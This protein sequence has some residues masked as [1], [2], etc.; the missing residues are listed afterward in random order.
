MWRAATLLQDEF[1]WTFGWT[2]PNLVLVCR[3]WF[4]FVR[5]VPM[6]LQLA[7]YAAQYLSGGWILRGGCF[8]ILSCYFPSTVGVRIGFVASYCKKRMKWWVQKFDL[9]QNSHCPQRLQFMRIDFSRKAI[10]SNTFCFTE[11]EWSNIS[12]TKANVLR[13][14]YRA[15]LTFCR[16]P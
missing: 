10:N 5:W 12:E 2:D 3:G 7:W 4:M 14:L 9:V 6:S 1:Y 16:I 11:Q 15:L 8:F 13:C